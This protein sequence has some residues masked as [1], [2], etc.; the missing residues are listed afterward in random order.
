MGGN[1]GIFVPLQLLCTHDLRGPRMSVALVA[2]QFNHDLES[3]SSD[4]MTIRRDRNTPAILPE[5][6]ATRCVLPEDSTAAYALKETFG[7]QLTLRGK[8]RVS[9]GSSENCR[10]RAVPGGSHPPPKELPAGLLRTRRHANVL[11]SV[12]PTSV[13]FG[14]SGESNW[15]DL[16]LHGVSIWKAGVGAYDIVWDWYCHCAGK[17]RWRYIASTQ[18]RIYVTLALPT[19]PWHVSSDVTDSQLPWIEALDYACSWARGVHL[20]DEAAEAVTQAVYDLG[21]G[22]V[23]YDCPGG[24]AAHYAK[25]KFNLTAF[26]DLL[27]GGLGNGVYVNCTD[28]ATILS[29]FANLLGCDWWQ[30]RMG[31]FFDLNPLLA[32]G[33]STWQRPCGW[34]GFAY[35]EVAWA[36]GCTE[37][38]VICDACLEVN[39]FAAST[40]PVYVPLMPI[41][42]LFGATGSGYYRD[43]LATPAGRPNCDPRPTTRKRRDLM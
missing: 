16:P 36:G 42:M 32:I 26:L 30:S 28:C 24:G 10:I 13:S 17:K 25:P 43:L 8:F 18:H 22:T 31:Y 5:W 19:L 2:L 41:N 34:P 1:A 6:E 21:H 12:H 11:G 9:G 3:A 27:R 15:V 40:T 38:D 4:A 33:S 14:P 23:T 37:N 39:A 29:T 20:F 7:N 35:H